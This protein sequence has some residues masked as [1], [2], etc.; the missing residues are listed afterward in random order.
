MSRW[1]AGN[2]MMRSK[3][4]RV[5]V[6]AVLFAVAGAIGVGAAHL[7]VMEKDVVV[8]VFSRGGCALVHEREFPRKP[9]CTVHIDSA[10]VAEMGE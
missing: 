8:C 6:A 4:I 9:R 10:S 7:A 3:L 1:I 2:D 5:A